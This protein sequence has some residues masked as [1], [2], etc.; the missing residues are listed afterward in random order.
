MQATLYHHPMACSTASRIAAAEAGASVIIETVNIFTKE[1]SGGGSIYDVS[2]L[3]Q[4]AALK[5][6]DG[7]V[8][9]ENVAI[10]LWLQAHGKREAYRHTPTDADYFQLVRWLGFCATELHKALL[11]P[12]FNP[13][14]PEEMKL[15]VM[16]LA[17]A[18]FEFL[19]DHLTSRLYLLG[20]KASAADA[21]LIWFLTLAP[22]AGYELKPFEHLLAYQER[23]MAR[24]ETAR[25]LS[26]DRAAQKQMASS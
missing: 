16:K 26:E 17:P 12:V 11:W 14:S 23:V 2:P 3:G 5:T 20:D 21:Y 8:L 6:T 18:K 24:P 10:L 7:E 15:A 25:V 4:V 1:T 19:D 9:T 13:T 22:A